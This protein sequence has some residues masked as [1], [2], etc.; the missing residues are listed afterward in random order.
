MDQLKKIIR[1]NVVFLALAFLPYISEPAIAN[2]QQNSSQAQSFLQPL[3][4]GRGS[5]EPGNVTSDILSKETYCEIMLSSWG[6][7]SCEGIEA[8]IIGYNGVVDTL[9]IEKPKSDGF[10]KFDDWDSSNKDAEIKKIEK[11]LI[12]GLEAQAEATGSNIKFNGW[13]VYPKL[14][15][16]TNVMMYAVSVIWDGE[17]TINIKASKF[18]RRGYVVFRFVPIEANLNESE[19]EKIV[20]DAMS[21]YKPYKTESYASFSSGDKVAAVG[22]LG[23]LAGLV[24]VKYGKAA[25]GG[26]LA[27]ALMFLKKGAVLLLLPLLWLGNLL[28]KIFRKNS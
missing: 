3:S 24:G 11:E 21:N 1:D 8:V 15:Q 22:A 14:N 26:F 12:L 16:E 28:I 2:A 23:V 4:F 9:I 27:I 13:K 18:D 19:L 7:S 10:V 6:W 25:V 5:L 17:E 20:L